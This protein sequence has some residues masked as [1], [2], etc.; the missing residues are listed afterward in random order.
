MLAVHWSPVANTKQ[1]LKKGIRKSKAGL[2][3]FP[4]TGHPTVDRWWLRVVRAERRPKHYNGFIFRITQE[5]LPAT[6]AGWD[7]WPEPEAIDSLDAPEA[8]VTQ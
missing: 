2:F 1:I 4:L 3:C 7:A 5:D 6:M 8:G